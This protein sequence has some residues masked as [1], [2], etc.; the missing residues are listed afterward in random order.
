MPLPP[1][2]F[3]M[4]AIWRCIFRSLLI[5]AGVGARALGDALLARVL[6]HVGVCALV[7]GHRRDDGDLALEHAVI[8]A[9][10]S[11]LV[12]HAAH[13]GHH[14]HDAAHAT[15]LRHLLD[16][17]GE[18]VEVELAR[19]HLPGHRR[20]FFRV[21]VFGGLL[22]EA[23][24]VAHAEDAIGDALGMKFL[25][26]I[27]LSPGADQLDRL[28]GDGA[29]RERRAAAAVAVHAGKHE[30]GDAD[31]LVEIACEV[32]GVLAGQ[33]SPPRAESRAATIPT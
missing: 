12:L 14:R 18:V 21:D 15:H 22:D 31:A 2:A 29:H 13:A 23:D 1:I 3:I 10:G 11:Q 32:D 17:A 33:R 8:E 25:Q 4:S 27:H 30:A 28:A 26:R 16:L 6:E 19:L 24:D 9:C 5:S 7:L 20:G